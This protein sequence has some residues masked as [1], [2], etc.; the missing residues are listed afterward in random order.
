MKIVV[1]SRQSLIDVAVQHGGDFGVAFDM[2]E[3][4]GLSLTDDLETGVELVA[5]PVVNARVVQHYAVNDIQPATAI[6]QEE[7]NA[8]LATGEGI[9]YWEIGYDFIIQ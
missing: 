8:I 3:A 2:A 5:P 1:S 7:I 4:N 6:T 9:G